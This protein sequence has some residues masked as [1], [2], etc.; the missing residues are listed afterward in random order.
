MSIVVLCSLCEVTFGA[1]N[2]TLTRII[3]STNLSNFPVTH[4]RIVVPLY[5]IK[6]DVENVSIKPVTE[7][8]IETNL[9]RGTRKKHF[10]NVKATEAPV[11]SKRTPSTEAPVKSKRTPKNY[12]D[13]KGNYH[14]AVSYSSR[15]D[16]HQPKNNKIQPLNINTKI[17][18]SSRPQNSAKPLSGKY[19]AKIRGK[20]IHELKQNAKDSRHK[21]KLEKLPPNPVD[22]PATS[23]FDNTG[24]YSYG[25]LHDDVIREPSEYANNQQQ[26]VTASGHPAQPKMFKSSFRDVSQPQQLP[27]V[28]QDGLGNFLYTSEILYPSY[29]H[30]LYPPVVTYG[31]NNVKAQ[32]TTKDLPAVQKQPKIES[33]KKKPV[34]ARQAQEDEE[35]YDEEESSEDYEEGA[36]NDRYDGE[37]P[38][39]DD[40]VDDE[41]DDGRSESFEKSAPS[42]R[43]AFDDDGG[44][45]SD[46][47]SD[48]FDKA[49]AKF[50]YGRGNSRSD[51]DEESDSGSYESSE[52]QAM[53]KRIKYFH[54][55][56]QEI[57]SP[58]KHTTEATLTTP[59][60]MKKMTKVMS[61]ALNNSKPKVVKSEEKSPPTAV[62]SQQISPRSDAADDL[63]YFQ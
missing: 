1:V 38:G 56:K 15:T 39:D 23:W 9:R 22:V 42:Y 49:W 10:E 4:E 6:K 55:K 18:K 43:Y 63:K 46:E 24:K 16:D 31:G 25:I 19:P 44:S 35:D 61:G 26:S 50:G 37:A 40:D 13:G 59:K 7:R 11:K 62:K 8:V 57:R 17:F 54:E 27:Q 60:P 2:Q 47:N 48:Q 28:K 45:R 5:P 32:P 36:N 21:L 41:E 30:N 52:T 3:P 34:E 12:D 14:N 29:R 20:N 51:S 33:P 58:S 53:P